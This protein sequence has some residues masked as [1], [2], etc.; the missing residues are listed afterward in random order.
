MAYISSTPYV[1]VYVCLCGAL[2]VDEASFMALYKA[3]KAG[4]TLAA[5]KKQEEV[6]DATMADETA[7]IY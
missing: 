5:Q 4:I 1:Y 2:Q 6:T 7:G 3:K